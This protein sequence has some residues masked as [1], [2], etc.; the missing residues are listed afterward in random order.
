M[1]QIALCRES[2]EF[3]VVETLEWCDEEADAES[4][5]DENW[6]DEEWYILDEHGN[7]CNG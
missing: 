1:Y 4:Y 3:E 6:G 5:A 7:N 2:G